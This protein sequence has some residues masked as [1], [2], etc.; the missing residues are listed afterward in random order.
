[1]TAPA[2]P[3]RAARWLARLVARDPAGPAILGDLHEDFVA[4]CHRRGVGNARWWYR[5]EVAA[6]ALDRGVHAALAPFRRNGTVHDLIR[7]PG[8]TR[9]VALA[10]RRFRREPA[11]ALLMIVVIGLGVGA[12]TAV[13]SVLRPLL[14]APLPFEEPEQLVWIEN[15]GDRASLSSVTSRTS[16]L[17]DFRESTRSFDGLTGYFAFFEQSSY[18]LV[19]DGRPEQFTGV[20]VADDFLDV[21]GV[22]PAL[23]RSF[24]AEEGAWGGPRAVILTHGLWVQRFAADP[25]VVGR[26]LTLNGEA[27]A[28][29][30][31]L[32]PS[33][34][35]SSVFKPGVP[36]DILV[37]FAI[38]DET[39]RWG[40]TLSIVGRLRPGVSIDQARADVESVL[41]GLREAQPERWGLTAR[42]SPLR[43]YVAGPFRSTLLLLAAAAGA[44]IL[45][46][47]VNVANV[48]LA[49]S[50]RRAR[51]VAVRKALGATR[52]RIVRQLLIESVVL[53]LAGGAVGTAIAVFV[54]RGVSATSGVDIPLLHDVRVEGTALGVAFLAAL[55]T[56]V[57]VGLVPALRV[58][59]GSES[60]TLRSTG[61]GASQG[62]S[63]RGLLEGLVVAEVALACVLLLAGGLFLRSFRAVLEVDLGY[64]PDGAVAWQLN[65]GVPLQSRAEMA[66][67]FRQVTAEV[68]GLPGVDEVGLVDALP[69]GKN[70][71]WGFRAV[72]EAETDEPLGMFPH[73]VDPGYRAAM[74]IPLLDG[75]DFSWDDTGETAPVVL[76]N[77]TAAETLYGDES[78]LGRQLAIGGGE[79]PW[80]IV[81]VVADVRHVSPEG[82]SGIEIYLPIAQRWDFG[83]L[84]LVVRSDRPVADLAAA[85]SSTLDDLDPSM[86]TREFTPLAATVARSV[87]PR[88]FTLRILSAFGVVALVLAGL[89][90]YGVL[91]HSVAER[92]REI[93]IRMAMGAT[94]GEVRRSLV[95][96]T[97]LL[98]TAG[99]VLGLAVGLP[100]T[101][102]VESLLFGVTPADPLT[103][104]ALSALL[105]GVAAAS[106]AI[107]AIRASRTDSMKVLRNE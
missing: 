4:R 52:G 55:V 93:A 84:D 73:L 13:Y 10:F 25:G 58:A 63:T 100:G 36:V 6:L 85:V 31:V 20:G 26:S 78:A 48:F 106:G 24:T 11:F 41:T 90:I 33:F 18:A 77:E 16:N 94:G 88:R 72:G 104:G 17:R 97:L 87:S 96:R 74:G 9:D 45:L 38:S 40:N 8:W 66:D 91:S 61:R 60:S 14:L 95:G 22:E 34:D 49:R 53:A 98:A 28:V 54:A 37:P 7:H 99:L 79:D 83:T 42:L 51:D 2:P 76:I 62:R 105:L 23:G 69:L 27:W 1:M 64:D 92:R 82:P 29:V 12:T 5:R 15:D 65:P 59:D 39:D 70:R 19:G 67:F 86:P 44:V 102:I 47:C 107:P 101:R 68:A 57:A 71:N 35:F 3:P 46:V 32:P 21:L 56:G 89:G 80:T 81:G 43:D 75:R 30:G 103:L 50:P